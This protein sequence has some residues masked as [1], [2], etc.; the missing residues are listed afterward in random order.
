MRR[1][2]RRL[3]AAASMLLTLFAAIAPAWAGVPADDLKQIEYKYY[4]RG[5]YPQAVEALQTFLARVDV[6]GDVALRAEEFLAASHV[7]SGA[8]AA[9][10][11]VFTRII[12]ANPE[13]PGPDAAVFKPEVVNVYGQAR[14]DYAS[15]ALHTAPAVTDTLSAPAG[16]STSTAVETASGKPIYKKWWFYAG[17]ASLV[18]VVA[19]VAGGGGGDEASAPRGTISVGVNVK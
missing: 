5:K 9:G 16:P 19:M 6:S 8:P 13:Y 1:K 7:L 14:S 12:A 10:K 4:F 2:T 3:T 11:D 18:G 17:A 15:L